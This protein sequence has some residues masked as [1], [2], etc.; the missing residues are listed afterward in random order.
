MQRQREEIVVL[1]ARVNNNVTIE[2]R[3][4][5]LFEFD[6]GKNPAKR[7]VLVVS[8]DSRCTDKLV[9]VIMLGDSNKGR[10]VVKVT[11]SNFESDKYVHCG[12]I[13]YTKRDYLIKEVGVVDA[14]TMAEID[15]VISR[16]FA[17]M[18]DVSTKA[19]FYERSYR[20]LLD[21]CIDK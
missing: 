9:N 16:E 13:T 19:E 17:I 14:E 10:D 6:D 2:A 5:H 18:E 11:N 3:R 1:E 20:E 8:C 4:G 12:M 7:Y 21:K 15:A